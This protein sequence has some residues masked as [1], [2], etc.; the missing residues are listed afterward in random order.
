MAFLRLLS[1]FRYSGKGAGRDGGCG[2]L[3]DRTEGLTGQN[4]G[5]GPRVRW[6]QS[7]DP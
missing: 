3:R 2:V 5:R 6:G 7:R 4:D 1:V